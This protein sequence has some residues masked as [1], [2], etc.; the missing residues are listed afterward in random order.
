LATAVGSS[1]ST[2]WVHD[3]QGDRQISSQGYGFLP[4][5][6]ADGKKLY[7]LVRVGGS[8]HFV[9][10]ELWV[11]DLTSGQRARLLPDFVMEHYSISPDGKRIVFV[12]A[13][14]MGHSPVWIAS[15]DGRSAPRKLSDFDALRAFF[16]ANGRVYFLSQQG[17]SRFVYRIDD[18]G[19]GLQKMISEPVVFAYS[20][21]PDGNSLALWFGGSSEER[22][23]SVVVYSVLD[24]SQ[25]TICTTCASAGGPDR[26]RTPPIVSWSPDGKFLY[27][28]GR[29]AQGQTYAVPLDDGRA[30]P[31]LP[32]GGTRSIA[33]VAA[34]P[35]AQLIA[36]QPVFVGS[37]P[38]QYAFSRVS[39]QR[40]IYRIPIP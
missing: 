2:V 32:P 28:T 34:L 3:A 5:F 26:G 16:G 27:L 9:S 24:G 36:R 14:A 21:S 30:V 37:D 12:M 35:G 31:P 33:D 25:V 6:S 7:Y 1:Q 38:S 23:N 40:N 18:D 15:F 17:T 22:L 11:S 13:D 20:V 19:R 8:R 4:S 29:G 10:G 39:T